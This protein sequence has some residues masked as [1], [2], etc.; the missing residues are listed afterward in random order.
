M[1]NSLSPTVELVKD[2]DTYTLNTVSTF[3]NTTISFKEGV[4]FEEE[5]IDGRKVQ[6]VC[7]F[8][9]ENKLIHEQG[10]DIP[11]TIIREFTPEEMI[12]TMKV[13]DVTAI[14]KYKAV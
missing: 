8:E 5:T 12:A 4:P 1:G 13:K 9:G 2:G 10:G 3:K 6:S 14:R 7:K 11:S